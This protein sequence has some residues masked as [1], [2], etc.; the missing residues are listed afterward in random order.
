MKINCETKQEII[1]EAARTAA[2][3]LLERP[4]GTTS[5]V[6]RV[7][8][9]VEKDRAVIIGKLIARAAIEASKLLADE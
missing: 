5:I 1:L 4:F 9:G 2:K 8:A 6:D 7:S 3:E